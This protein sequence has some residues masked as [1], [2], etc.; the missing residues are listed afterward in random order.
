[1]EPW[2]I[3]TLV[4]SGLVFL[5]VLIYVIIMLSSRYQ[6]ERPVKVKK[7]K[8]EYVNS[9]NNEVK[10]RP[11]VNKEGL[12]TLLLL[13]VAAVTLEIIFLN[14]VLGT[15]NL[16]LLVGGTIITLISLSSYVPIKH[17]LVRSIALLIGLTFIG[18]SLFPSGQTVQNIIVFTL[19]RIAIVL[20]IYAAL[21]F[22]KRLPSIL[23]F[24]AGI[25]G[26]ILL[27]IFGIIAFFVFGG[28]AFFIVLLLSIFGGIIFLAVTILTALLRFVF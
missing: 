12:G 7:V 8:P 10:R 26:S 9:E 6:K 2:L 21:N 4:I 20:L 5:G 23:S 11:S 15:P 19:V 28:V 16:I 27:F 18:V 13:L 25:I 3:I 24:I 1:M 17:K 14:S 22:I